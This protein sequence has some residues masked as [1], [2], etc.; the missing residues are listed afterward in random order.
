VQ[1][2]LQNVAGFLLKALQVV[3]N[4]NVACTMF[5]NGQNVQVSRFASR[6]ETSDT[7]LP[8]CNYFILIVGRRVSS[9]RCS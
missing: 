8:D 4:S 9:R 3:K 6:D 1:C 2:C 5:S 7:T